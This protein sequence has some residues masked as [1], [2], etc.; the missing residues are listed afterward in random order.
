M[1]SIECQPFGSH[2]SRHTTELSSWNV[3]MPPKGY[4]TK[5]TIADKGGTHQIEKAFTASFRCYSKDQ[6]CNTRLPWTRF[7]RDPTD[8]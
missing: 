5:E 4:R 2:T 1:A 7:T 6:T 3:R 8:R